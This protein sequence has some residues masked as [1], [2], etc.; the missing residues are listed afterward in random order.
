[1]GWHP[2]HSKS[3]GINRLH[4]VSRARNARAGRCRYSTGS[5][6]HCSICFIVWFDMMYLQLVVL[7]SM[8]KICPRTVPRL[9]LAKSAMRFAIVD[10]S[11]RSVSR[12]RHFAAAGVHSTS[13][14]LACLSLFG[15]HTTMLKSPRRI[16]LFGRL[17]CGF[18]DFADSIAPY[19]LSLPRA[20]VPLVSPLPCPAL[21]TKIAL[22]ADCLCI[23]AR[24]WRGTLPSRRVRAFNSTCLFRV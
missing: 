18:E 15:R 1:M 6:V 20:L 22:P 3:I 7:S 14:K 5:C 24:L 23:F 2:E 4:G 12:Y 9:V 17:L 13:Q 16:H 10:S 21:S 19:P 11:S 8:L